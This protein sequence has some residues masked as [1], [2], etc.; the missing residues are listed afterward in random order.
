MPTYDPDSPFNDAILR[1]D[2][3]ETDPLRHLA[4]QMDDLMRRGIQR[5]HLT[6]RKSV[7]TVK[8]TVEPDRDRRVKLSGE[9]AAKLPQPPTNK[10]TAYADPEEGTLHDHD[11]YA[12]HS[13]LPGVSVAAPPR[14]QPA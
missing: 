10:V 13:A 12:A 3:V 9:V 11:V 7:I 6:G 1:I 4:V 14:K 8:L 2:S 5:T